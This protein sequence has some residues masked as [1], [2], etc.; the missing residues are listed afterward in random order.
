MNEASS[1]S[2]NSVDSTL[3]SEDI[4][5]LDTSSVTEDVSGREG[6]SAEELR[7]Q[8]RLVRNRIS[9]ERSRR[10]RLSRIEDLMAHNKRLQEELESLQAM[11]VENGYLKRQVDPSVRCLPIVSI[12]VLFKLPLCLSNSLHKTKARKTLYMMLRSFVVQS[13]K[14]NFRRVLLFGVL[15]MKLLG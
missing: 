6:P 2:H 4:N 13:H 9:A 8:K 11:E 15:D 12:R 7:R 3:K 14:G 1:Y 10:R 5:T